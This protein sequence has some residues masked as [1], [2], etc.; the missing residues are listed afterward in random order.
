M[1]FS[2]SNPAVP[3]TCPSASC[4]LVTET[5]EAYGDVVLNLTLRPNHHPTS[6]RRSSSLLSSCIDPRP[7][8]LQ[9]EF[10]PCTCL[11]PSFLLTGIYACLV[12]VGTK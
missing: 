2:Y 10:V 5:G 7:K 8:L 4:R 3:L 11:S 9:L 1:P 6:M 12:L